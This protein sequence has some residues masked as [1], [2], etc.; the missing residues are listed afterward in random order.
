MGG[1]VKTTLIA[2]MKLAKTL[3]AMLLVSSA[4]ALGVTIGYRDGGK[5]VE[6]SDVASMEQDI[7]IASL[8]AEEETTFSCADGGD[9]TG[10]WTTPDDT[11]LDLADWTNLGDWRSGQN[12]W[13][14][15]PDVGGGDIYRIKKFDKYGPMCTS[16]T[17]SGRKVNHGNPFRCTMAACYYCCG[18]QTVGW[19]GRGCVNQCMA[20]YVN[21]I[22]S[23]R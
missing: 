19:F 9:G 7:G 1:F 17:A 16:Q 4:G 3:V 5:A 13:M 8:D 14:A 10:V 15:D 2:E 23:S 20:E 21:A 18:T 6:L 11:G 22:P 12:F